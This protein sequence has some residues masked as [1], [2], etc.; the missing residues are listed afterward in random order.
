[1]NQSTGGPLS[2]PKA[3]HE[4]IAKAL[5]T[6][7]DLQFM[8]N[9][10]IHVYARR[11]LPEHAA[12]GES[13]NDN[14]ISCAI[15]PYLDVVALKEVPSSAE[16]PFMPLVRKA[17]H[18][19][20]WEHPGRNAAALRFIA[21]A[22]R[23]DLRDADLRTQWRVP[24][25]KSAGASEI[26]AKVDSPLSLCA[27]RLNGRIVVVTAARGGRVILWD[28]ASG[29]SAELCDQRAG[30]TA[31]AAET[32]ADG[33][34]FVSIASGG[35]RVRCWRVREFSVQPAVQ[36]RADEKRPFDVGGAVTALSVTF[37]NSRPQI[38]AG[39]ASG[40]VSLLDWE[41]ESQPWQPLVHGGRVTGVTSVRLANDV[42]AAVSVSLDG[43]MLVWNLRGRLVA[44]IPRIRSGEAIRAVTAVRFP[45]GTPVAVTAGAG[46]VRIWDLPPEEPQY[47]EVA[48]H[49]RDVVTLAGVTGPQGQPLVVTGDSNGCL[50]VVDP[51]QATV[52]SGPVDGHRGRITGLALS[53]TPDG[54]PVAVS[55]GD[56][57]TVRRWNLD[58]TFRSGPLSAGRPGGVNAAPLGTAAPA[59][60]EQPVRLWRLDNGRELGR[61][62][63]SHSHRMT[64]AAVCR[65][66][67]GTSVAVTDPGGPPR[68]P[69]QR[70]PIVAI[71]TAALPDGRTVA[72]AANADGRLQFWE[73]SPGQAPRLIRPAAHP[74]A[75]HRG[76]RL[77]VTARL[78]DGRPVAVSAGLDHVLR[79]WDLQDGRRLDSGR[80][81]HD[82]SVTALAA[83][84][85]PDR[86]AAV[87]SGSADTTL[88]VWSVDS[89]QRIGPIV[90][91]NERQI[92][93]VAAAYVDDGLIAVTARKGDGVVRKWGLLG[94]DPGPPRLTGH[95]G[96][97]TAVAIA[98]PAERPV[99][100]TAGEDRTVRVWD[101]MSSEPVVDP[102]PVP[103]IVRAIACFDSGGPSAVIA[104]DDVLAV[105]RW[106]GR[107]QRTSDMDSW[108][109]GAS[110][111]VT[112]LTGA[113]PRDK[114]RPGASIGKDHRTSP[115]GAESRDSQAW[116][117]DSDVLHRGHA[118][119]SYVREDSGEVDE[120]QQALEAAGVPVWRDTA[121]LW[122]GED[123]GAMI[124]EAI[125]QD[126][127]V[128]IACF[129]SRSTARR[130]SYQNA[131]L[132]LAID[133]L[134][135]RQP[136]TPWL[137]PVRFDR[138]DIPDLDLG[139][140]RTLRS[141]QQ[142]DLFGPGRGRATE[143]LVV[144]VK[145]LLAKD[146]LGL[147]C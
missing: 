91:G 32:A 75:A 125:T 94:A 131:E 57:G 118:F 98:G 52:I 38:L 50:R 145:R 24:W 48:G 7:A 117:S 54:C 36:L 5:A 16:L 112:G 77:V 81:E 79:M 30:V 73:L 2:D 115:A 121:S 44:M 103:G 68:V 83:A 17:A 28:L 65:L 124:R 105:V 78:A 102:M 37:I 39:Q 135:S 127:L 41:E 69:G 70:G 8:T 120:L 87:V 84:A 61:D 40:K 51:T 60:A 19:W 29:Q 1:M 47:R 143:R 80:A 62:L 76:V 146:H 123:W 119:I 96:P 55:S 21:A 111:R 23:Y 90:R 132:L 139:G 130:R 134:K 43:S 106:D 99:V 45:D 20:S 126:T 59:E 11:H 92:T 33:S 114:D 71:A 58:G 63:G 85:A 72:I 141:L 142:S 136:G 26:L 104:G 6:H 56:D 137:I 35:G 3:V 22:E 14:I 4:R 15:L 107:D 129:S 53:G 82:K 27:A 101:L 108:P 144:A 13:M 74:P 18:A 109:D 66:A 12:A 31:T 116:V 34:V 25:A 122:P 110:G 64:A 49:D 46:S 93:A 9:A 138:C 140:G 147:L 100:V 88:R 42:P 113:E 67:D 95:E 10:Q 89:G 128:F 86:P 133:E 97:V